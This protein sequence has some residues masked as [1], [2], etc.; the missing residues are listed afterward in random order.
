ML[1]REPSEAERR[2]LVQLYGGELDYFA[3]A[4]S[5]AEETLNVGLATRITDIAE[6][7]LAAWTSVARTL[8]NLNESINRN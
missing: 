1:S 4:P 6:E 2:L 5:A 8:L 7:E 3:A